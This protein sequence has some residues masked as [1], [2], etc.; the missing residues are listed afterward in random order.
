MVKTSL[1]LLLNDSRVSRKPSYRTLAGLFILVLIHPFLHSMD[2][3]GLRT[4][5]GLKP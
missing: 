1:Y 2:M 4:E 3:H 5:C